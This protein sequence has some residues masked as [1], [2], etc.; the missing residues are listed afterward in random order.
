MSDS[1]HQRRV[2]D[3]STHGI[4]WRTVSEANDL[5]GLCHGDD[6]GNLQGSFWIHPVSPEE[7]ASESGSGAKWVEGT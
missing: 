6:R 1:G 4:F 2:D 7:M 5:G 3:R